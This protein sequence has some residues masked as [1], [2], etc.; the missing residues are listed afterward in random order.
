MEK[1]VKECEMFL[2]DILNRIF[3]VVNDRTLT[4]FL[5]DLPEIFPS[6]FEVLEALCEDEERMTL[7][8]STLR[9][10]IHFRPAVRL[11]AFDLLLKYCRHPGI[12][13]ALNLAKLTRGTAIIT[14]KRWFSNEDTLGLSTA[15]EEYALEGVMELKQQAPEKPEG[16]EMQGLWNEDEVASRLELFLALCS[17]PN[18]SKEDITLLK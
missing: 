4:R 17:K 15:I 16:D 10:L 14:I 12:F 11:T 18:V 3:E 8:I 7:G 13:N 9:D 6:G 2:S 1:D 5:I